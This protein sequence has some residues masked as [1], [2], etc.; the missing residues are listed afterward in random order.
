MRTINANGLEMPAL[1]QGTW[2]MGEDPESE[3]RELEALKAGLS[4]GMS[5]IDTAEMYGEGLAEKLTGKAIEGANRDSIFLVSKVYPFNAGRKFIFNSCEASLR[6]LGVDCLDLYLL[7]WRGSVPLPETVQCMEELVKRGKIKRW[8]VSN[9]DITDMEELWALPDGEN[10]AANQV[11]Y[12]LGSRGVEHSLLPALKRRGVGLMA[13]CPLG[14]SS[15][16][17]RAKIA[18]NK[19][20]LSICEK[21]GATIS[22]LMIA[23]ALRQPNVAAI[24][25][26]SRP[27]HAQENA[28]ALDLV[29]SAGEWELVDKEFP[30]PARKVPLDIE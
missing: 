25:K 29:L 18:S 10:C 5:M 21:H 9:F 30:A 2:R 22:Q 16:R 13:Y 11:L 27:S 26:A 28:K 14:G 3:P 23:F 17:A 20:L 15:L 12:H 4:S 19:T 7:H 6:R 1:G 24:P 8:G